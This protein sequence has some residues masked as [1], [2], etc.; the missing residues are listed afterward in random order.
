MYRNFNEIKQ[1]YG[2]SLHKAF[3]GALGGAIAIAFIFITGVLPVI[4]IFL[5][6]PVGWFVYLT[7]VS[8]RALS[9]VRAKSAPIYAF[10]HPISSL[11]LIYLITYSWNRRGA[12]QWKGRT[13]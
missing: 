10:L 2:K 13:V 8:T 7:I 3:G 11:I 1:G 12:I 6:S 5:G 9:A 4:L